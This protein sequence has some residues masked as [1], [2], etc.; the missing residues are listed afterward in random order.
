MQT[1]GG[2]IINITSIEAH[3]AAPG[4]AVYAA[5]KAGVTSLTRTLAVELAP[6]GIRVNTIAPDYI[7]TPALATLAEG[8]S[9]EAVALQH[10]I[11]TPMG[12]VGQFED[13]GGCALFLASN[14][15]SFV[16][17]TTL[18]PDGGALAS[19]G[20]MNWPDGGYANNPPH[21]VVEFLLG[22]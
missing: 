2:S 5:M 21:Y 11:G 18:H 3:R 1:A 22:R 13:A 20:W 10:Q 8:V 4:F 12:R 14:L 6:K 9:E 17:G 16:T 19:A 7:V 15:S